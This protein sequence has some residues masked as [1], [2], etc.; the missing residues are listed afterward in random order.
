MSCRTIVEFNHDLGPRIQDDPE[1]FAE[2]IMRMLNSGTSDPRI[3]DDL[4]RY[5]ITATPTTHHT[6]KRTVQIG[7]DEIRL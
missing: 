6:V 5:G 4:R 2:V 1:G 3:L 7:G